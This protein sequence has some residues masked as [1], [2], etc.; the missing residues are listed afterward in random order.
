MNKNKFTRDEKIE[1]AKLRFLNQRNK[2]IIDKWNTRRYTLEEI[3]EGLDITRERVRQIIKKA[4]SYGI[5]VEAVESVSKGR[6]DAY[7]KK[8]IERIDSKEF[9]ELYESGLSVREITN[10]LITNPPTPEYIFQKLLKMLHVEGEI[11]YKKHTVQN[12]KNLRKKISQK[13]EEIAIRNTIIIM[14]H[15]DKSLKEIATACDLSKPAISKRIRIMKAQGI[16]VPSSSKDPG[17]YEYSLEKRNK[18][19]SE[20]LFEIDSYLEQGIPISNIS[21]IMNI[22]VHT[23]YELIYEN[24]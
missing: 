8:M 6:S 18:K 16:F 22:N 7:I 13:P 24:F 1:R 20:E 12:I 14:R 17:I 15:Q 19:F 2:S 23:L 4:K 10:V 9:I 11:S 21:T 5:H 3:G